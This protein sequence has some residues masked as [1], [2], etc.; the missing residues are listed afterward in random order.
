MTEEQIKQHIRN[1]G[2]TSYNE[3]SHDLACRCADSLTII[4]QLQQRIAELEAARMAYASEF[5]L[6]ADG[7]PDVGNIHANIRALKA[8]RGKENARRL[9]IDVCYIEDEEPFIYGINGKINVGALDELEKAIIEYQKDEDETVHPCKATGDYVFSV[10]FESPET[11]DYGRAYSTGY[12]DLTL[13]SFKPYEDDAS[14]LT[15]E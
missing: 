13:V 10:W 5:P 2:E 9:L 6:N 3:G 14:T 12:W 1:L 4:T 7:E 11:D 15:K 8:E